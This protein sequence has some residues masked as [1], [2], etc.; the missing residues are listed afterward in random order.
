M[1]CFGDAVSALML[2]APSIT[3]DFRS[4]IV[5]RHSISLIMQQR[6]I[7]PAS[8]FLGHRQLLYLPPQMYHGIHWYP[9]LPFSGR[10]FG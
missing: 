6:H 1:K 10:I 5:S 3:F 9:A 2:S 4:W 8:W 7:I